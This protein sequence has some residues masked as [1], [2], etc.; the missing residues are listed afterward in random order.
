MASL[1]PP[2]SWQ[3]H[4]H[5]KRP[6]LHKITSIS[7]NNNHFRCYPKLKSSLSLPTQTHQK[8]RSPRTNN[9]TH[10]PGSYLEQGHNLF[11]SGNLNEAINFLQADFDNAI[12]S[13]EQRKEAIVV[14]LQACGHHNDIEL[15]R[16]LHH[17][18]SASAQFSNHLVLITRIITTYSMRG[19]P[20]D[21]RSVFDGLQRKNLLHWNALPSGYA[22]NELFDDVIAL[23]TELISVTELTPDNFYV[24]LCD[25]GL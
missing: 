1:T 14:L 24:A 22:T 8:E 5:Q 9:A 7:N 4:H 20:S 12:S 3:Y 13:S 16:K 15:G 25:Q 18:V 10:H 21:S 19:S 11:E 2:L 6:I 17:M 23:F